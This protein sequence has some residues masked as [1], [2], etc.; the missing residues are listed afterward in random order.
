MPTKE[1]LGKRAQT[2]DLLKN[3]ASIGTV[4][5]QNKYN[6]TTCRHEKNPSKNILFYAPRTTIEFHDSISRKASWMDLSFL[7]G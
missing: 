5:N 4:N 3:S 7:F 2:T 6:Q 1:R